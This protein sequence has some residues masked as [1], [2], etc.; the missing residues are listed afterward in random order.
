MQL[1]DWLVFV[2]FGKLLIYFWMQFPIPNVLTNLSF[3][4]KLHECD[5]CS[6]CWIYW[7]LAVALRFDLLPALGLPHVPI[8]GE[9]LTGGA[10]S[11]LVHVFSIG[12]KAKYEVVHL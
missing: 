3:F 5:L 12:V 10:I 2:A 8:V 4:R 6:G 11:Y 1:S 7:V 9:F